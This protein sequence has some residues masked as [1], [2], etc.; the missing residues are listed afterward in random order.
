VIDREAALLHH[1]F[2]ITIAQ[3][4]TQ[5]PADAEKDDLGFIVTP[6][7]RIGFSQSSPR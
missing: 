7:E 1:F 3:T 4:V 5:I 2:E 6:L